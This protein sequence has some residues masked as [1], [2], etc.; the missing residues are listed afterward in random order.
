M[1]HS[2]LSAACHAYAV[3]GV[4]YLIYLFK[5]QGRSWQVG[6][7]ALLAGFLTHAAVIVARYRD[8]TGTPVSSLADG[9][10]FMAWLMVGVYLVLDRVYRLPAIGAFVT[11]LAL[12]ITVSALLVPARHG[13]LDGQPVL[14]GLPGLAAHVTG[15]FAGLA[16]FAL[17]AGVAVM[18]LVQE[19]QMKGKHFGWI[20]NRLPSLEVLDEINRRLVVIGFALLSFT[21]ATGAYFAKERWGEYLSWDP[22]EVFSLVAWGVFATLIAARLQVGWRGR[23]VALLTMVG[24]GILLASFVGLFAFPVGQHGAMMR[25][26]GRSVPAALR[27]RHHG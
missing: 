16:S 27:S 1:S 25:S 20:F 19:R 10:S 26:E 13:P 17:A 11:P 9:L 24:T 5:Q 18:Y 7:L 3:A 23:K 15:A 6:A 8:M 14:S 22:K 2:L 12:T 4:A 21:I